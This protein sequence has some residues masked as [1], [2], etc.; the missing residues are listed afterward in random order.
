MQV[1][2]KVPYLDLIFQIEADYTPGYPA[3]TSGPPDNW[4]PGSP[5]E[6][7]DVKAFVL[8]SEGVPAGPDISGLLSVVQLPRD[9]PANRSVLDYLLD[10]AESLLGRQ[11]D[12][13]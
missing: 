6:W 5:A 8:D 2:V 10:E 1:E 11:E 13:R 4:D 7:N 12:P 3:N 9:E